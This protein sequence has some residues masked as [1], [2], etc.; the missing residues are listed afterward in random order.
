MEKIRQ[1]LKDLPTQSGV[2]IMKSAGN[3]ILY[4]GKARNLKNR[5]NQYFSNSANKTEKTIRLVS[6]IADFEYIIT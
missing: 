5:V 4:V 3:Q 2:Y 6:H 1:K